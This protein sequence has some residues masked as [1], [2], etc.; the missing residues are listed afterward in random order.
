[1]IDKNINTDI[2]PI[3]KPKDITS[4]EVVRRIKKI[5][6]LEKAGHCGT[7][8]PFAEGVVIVLSNNKTK[9]SEK[10]MNDIKV[11]E[12]TIM[13]GLQTDTLDPTGQTLKEKEMQLGSVSK[14][15]IKKNLKKFIGSIKQRPPCFSA[16]RVNGVRLYKLARKDVF[17]H[18]KP[19]DVHIEDI[20]LISHSK[21]EITIEVRCHKGVYIRQLG[22]DIAN[23][24]GTIGYLKSLTR[25]SIGKFTQDNS[26]VFETLIN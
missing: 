8:D 3:W 18:L 24:L 11:Y 9:E 5:Y 1:M 23:S 4:S 13:L 15:E 14:E 25:K 2:Y 16:K 22:I 6:N 20:N 10:Y 17:V 7:L 19:V 26:I 12:T 21:N